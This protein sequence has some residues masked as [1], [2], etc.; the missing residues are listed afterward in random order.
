VAEK[1][2]TGH[3][4]GPCFIQAGRPDAIRAR[5]LTRIITKP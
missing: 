3:P 2:A 1:Y 4:G 5:S